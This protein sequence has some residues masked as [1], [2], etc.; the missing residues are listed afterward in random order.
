[1]Q[2]SAP[3]S[4]TRHAATAAPPEPAPA[5]YFSLHAYVYEFDDGAI[6][7]DLRNDTYVG[8]DVQHLSGLRTRI[9]NWPDSGRRIREGQ[10]HDTSTSEGLIPAFLP[11]G[12]LTTSP[13]PRR[14][15][16]A[17]NPTMA[18]TVASSGPAR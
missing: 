10:R 2:I 17:R 3:V 14:P 13:T 4:Q 8:V 6:I 9:G 18:L 15:P 5:C 16:A 11:R 12:I 7:L 1:M